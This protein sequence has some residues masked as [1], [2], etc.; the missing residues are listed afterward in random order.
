MSK[1]LL[2]QELEPCYEDSISKE[3]YT[4]ECHWEYFD[5]E[6]TVNA[7]ILDYSMGTCSGS[8]PVASVGIVKVGKDTIRVI[9][10]CTIL[11]LKKG[12]IVELIPMKASWKMELSCYYISNI[13]VVYIGKV[14]KWKRFRMRPNKVK[15]MEEY[16]GGYFCACCPTV[17]KTTYAQVL[18]KK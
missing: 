17:L 16:N 9:D 18:K 6:D 3:R 8:R 5:L 15:D 14:S 4:Y 11:Q 7:I 13:E 12:D 10:Y 1:S 2:S